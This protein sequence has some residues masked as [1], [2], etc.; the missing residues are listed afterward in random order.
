VEE[1]GTPR[2]ALGMLPEMDYEE[3]S[4]RLEPGETVLFYTDG[5]FEIA[6]SAG[7]ELGMKGLQKMVRDQ[8][9]GDGRFQLGALEE[10]LL[11]FSNQVQLPDDL[12][13]LKLRR[14]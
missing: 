4:A 1:L 12:T 3:H 9:S 14:R 11:C 2:P 5:A 13:L 7:N 6:N 10:S 8:M